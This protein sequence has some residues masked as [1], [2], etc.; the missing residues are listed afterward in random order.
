MQ[1][2]LKQNVKEKS[3]LTKNKALKKAKKERKRIKAE[4]ILEL[5]KE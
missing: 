1:K 4:K 5:K 2:E 3:P